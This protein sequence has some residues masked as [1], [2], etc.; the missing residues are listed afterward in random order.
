MWIFRPESKDWILPLMRKKEMVELHHTLP[1]LSYLVL[2]I[3]IKAMEEIMF[4][5]EV[6]F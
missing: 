2:Q 6:M 4:D 3:Y 1:H 5:Y